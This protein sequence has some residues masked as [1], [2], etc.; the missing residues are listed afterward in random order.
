MHIYKYVYIHKL[1]YTH[2][3]PCSASQ[4]TLEAKTAQ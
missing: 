4:E 1:V 3:F 2:V